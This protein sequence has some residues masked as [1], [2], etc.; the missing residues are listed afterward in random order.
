M[1]GILS[2][3]RVTEL[4]KGMLCKF[5]VSGFDNTQKSATP[6]KMA[7]RTRVEM[8]SG[9]RSVLPVYAPW[10]EI[11]SPHQYRIIFEVLTLGAFSCNGR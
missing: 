10:N 7:M 2:L 4:L 1:S 9:C 5:P 3:P 11:S 8:V 6:D